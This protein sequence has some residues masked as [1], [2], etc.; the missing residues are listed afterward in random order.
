MPFGLVN[1]GTTFCRMIRKILHGVPNVDSFVDDMWIFTENWEDHKT[2]LRQVLDR[3]RSAKLTAKPSKCMIGYGSI[4]CLGHS[5]VGKNG[6]T[7]GGQDTGHK[8]CVAS[9]DKT[10]AKVFPWIGCF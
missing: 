3:L 6:A 7:A 8:G 1:S 4:E 2:S 10:T 5:I 9:S